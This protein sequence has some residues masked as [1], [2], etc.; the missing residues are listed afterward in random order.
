MR[1]RLLAFLLL[2]CLMAACSSSGNKDYGE[3]TPLDLDSAPAASTEMHPGFMH[4][5]YGGFEMAY[6]DDWT[7]QIVSANR[8]RIESPEDDSVMYIEAVTGLDQ[9]TEGMND[10]IT[11]FRQPL[12]EQ[13][14]DTN[15][16]G[17]LNRVLE[18]EEATAEE[19]NSP[20][21]LGEKVIS[22]LDLEDS[23]GSYVFGKFSEHRCYLRYNNMD[24]CISLIRPAG[25]DCT[26]ILKDSISSIAPLDETITKV[27][28][29][30]LD[31]GNSLTLPASFVKDGPICKVPEDNGSSLSGCFVTV[32]DSQKVT[33][34]L[35]NDLFSIV[36][37]AEAY[38]SVYMEPTNLSKALKTEESYKATF[39]TSGTS[40]FLRS[41]G[42]WNMDITDYNGKLIAVCYPANRTEQ[43]AKLYE[44]MF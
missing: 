36:Y 40:A 17:R 10:V 26:S 16:Y 22:S 24:F 18:Q 23:A 7:G 34:V 35:V 15:E 12:L 13:I 4:Y 9:S 8:V 14:I 44:T 38:A 39:S 25:E 33:P 3:I 5:Y 21:V 43:I 31:G 28:K 27:K 19:I 30:N 11:A 37:G 20:Y 32:F 41:I 42:M 6:P 2:C 29:F 1:K